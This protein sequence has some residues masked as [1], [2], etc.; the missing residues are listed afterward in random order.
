MLVHPATP[1]LC[2]A[3][4]RFRRN[5]FQSGP[6]VCSLCVLNRSADFNKTYFGIYIQLCKIA[7]NLNSDV[8]FNHKPL[9]IKYASECNKRC[10]NKPWP[11]FLKTIRTH[12]KNSL[13][14][15][16]IKSRDIKTINLKDPCGNAIFNSPN[17]ILQL[18]ICLN[19]NNII[20]KYSNVCK[21]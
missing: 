7:S 14:K 3:P 9:L 15:P 13:G 19:K 5:T 17:Y 21:M 6:L 10:H 8:R 1:N 20:Y 16:Q 18:K 4:S 12:Q 2:C 11:A